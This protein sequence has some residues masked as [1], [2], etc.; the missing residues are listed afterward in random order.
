[1]EELTRLGDKW[2]TLED[3][4]KEKRLQFKIEEEAEAREREIEAK[5]KEDGL[6]CKDYNDIVD[7][8]KGDEPRPIEYKLSREWQ[9]RVTLSEDLGQLRSVLGW[10]LYQEWVKE[11]ITG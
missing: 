2:V 9:S 4:F 3:W 6:R 7:G 5:E 11:T 8:F 1:M 10:T